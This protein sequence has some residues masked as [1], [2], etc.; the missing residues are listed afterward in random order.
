MTLAALMLGVL[1][2]LAL[3][4]IYV[5]IAT[6]LTL[7]LS[8][9][10]VFNFAQS[11]LVMIG[12]LLAFIFGVRYGWPPVIVVA[13]VTA[14]GMSGGVLTYVVAVWPAIGRAR[15][16]SHTTVLTTIGFAT[17]ANATIALLFGGDSHPVP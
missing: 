2:G 10:G 5:L 9:S 6:S 12:T 7:V 3:A 16:F 1:T 4:S 13:L 15:A 14:V 8:A 17:A 11:S